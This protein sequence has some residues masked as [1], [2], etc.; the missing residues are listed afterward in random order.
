[1][2]DSFF[3]GIAAHI[4]VMFFIANSR[5]FVEARL[6]LYHLLLSHAAF[7]HTVSTP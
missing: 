4:E 1:M 7:Y 2:L 5:E 6:R 3:D